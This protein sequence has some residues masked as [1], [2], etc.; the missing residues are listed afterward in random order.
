MGNVPD[1][2]VICKCLNVLDVSDDHFPLFNY[3]RKFTFVKAVKLLI[4]A[5]LNQRS[6]LEDISYH[7]DAN[8]QLQHELGLVSISAS[9]IGRTLD[10]LPLEELQA[11]WCRLIAQRSQ[12]YPEPSVADLGKLRI[13]DS[14]VL[15]L[16][17]VAGKWAYSSKMSNGV[18]IHTN[19]VLASPGVHYADQIICSTRGVADSEVA[20]DL[21][22]DREA[23]HVMDRG[24]IVYGQYKHW[25]DNDI[26]FVARIQKNSKTVV[27]KERD[28]SGFPSL[29]RDADV[30]VSYKDKETKESVEVLL[31]LV[32][33]TDD[34]QNVY[35][36]LTN[37]WD[38]TAVEIAEIYRQ[39]W[40]I[41]LF[42]K[43]MKQ[44]MR[45]VHL[46]SYKPDAVWNQIYLAM[47]AHA[48]LQLLHKEYA[49]KQSLWS[50]LKLLRAYGGA[51]WATF[52]R[53]LNRMPT[54]R[55]LGR[56]KKRKRGRP[57]VHPEVHKTVKLIKK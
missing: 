1:Q 55:S 2:T 34:K 50:F 40:A 45:L 41:E 28:V 25:L 7:L 15:S 11:L 38:R 14:T 31:R 43:W 54:K 22:V 9:Q 20:L 52:L 24:Y 18:K 5:Q 6:D 39:R 37:V 23:I 19:V 51:E 32:E 4:E 17:E 44:H 48:L 27:K 29:L 33:Y 46:Y 53:R 35:R 12:A 16:P 49:T 10:I 3:R 26:R 36:V 13:I 30:T 56:R 21:V 47:I 57:R 42:F 8:P